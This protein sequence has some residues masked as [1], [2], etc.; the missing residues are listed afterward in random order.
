LAHPLDQANI[1]QSSF[2]SQQLESWGMLHQAQREA[3]IDQCI[4][5]IPSPTANQLKVMLDEWCQQQRID[6][7]QKL[8]RWQQQQGFTSQQWEQFVVRRNCWLLW[9]QQ[10]LGDKLNSHYLKRKNQLDQVSYSLLRVKEKHLANELHL[11]IKEGEASFEEIAEAFSEGRERRQR[12]QLGP[13][14][15]SQPHPMLAKLL[16]VSTPKQLWPPKQLENWWV[17]VRLEQLH[18]AELTDSLKQQLLLELGDQHLEEQL[19]AAKTKGR[20]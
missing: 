5:C 2:S 3:V 8:H 16:R 11:R 15:L 20:A 17:V 10:N 7:P 13:V 6:S 18:C 4:Q 9:C 14:P 1:P 19:I 12:G